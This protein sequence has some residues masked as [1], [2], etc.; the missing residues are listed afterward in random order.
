MS[1]QIIPDDA[2]WSSVP[3][4]VLDLEGNGYQPP[5]LVELAVIPINAGVAGAA[6]TWLVRPDQKITRQV[7]R[8]HGI[9]N[10]DVAKAPRFDEVSSD[11]AASL[12]GRYLVAHNAAI[13]WDV[14]HRK[15]PTLRPPGVLDTLRLARAL[16]PGHESYKLDNLIVAFN[17]QEFLQGVG[18]GRHR[19]E[20]DAIAALQL[21]LFLVARSPRG[22]LS[23]RELVTLGELPCKA[24][25]R[26]QSLLL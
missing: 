17:L 14:L 19:A 12:E 16:C 9:K 6:R 25:N 21:F 4:A 22:H 3:F 2:L 11:V 18:A 23:F 15:L 20:Y 26:Q 8:I 1:S 7:T 10:A 13:D 24:E 5:D